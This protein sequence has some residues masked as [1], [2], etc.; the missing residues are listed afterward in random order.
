MASM[1]D[2]GH[3]SC[4]LLLTPSRYDGSHRT[5]HLHRRACR[6]REDRGFAPAGGGALPAEPVRGHP[7]RG[8]HGPARRPVPAAAVGAVRRGARPAG[9]DAT[10]SGP[11]APHRDYDRLDR[12][13]ARAARQRHVPADRIRRRRALRAARR[14]G[15]ASVAVGGCGGTAGRGCLRGPFHRGRGRHRRPAARGARGHL[16]SLAPRAAGARV[17]RAS[18]AARRGGGPRRARIAVPGDRRRLPVL[19]RR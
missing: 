9:G 16:R 12:G 4:Y 7:G 13:R 10:R 6:V 15:R 11:Q 1:S 3:E 8:A 2:A 19:S 5:P 18:V 14:N 17:A